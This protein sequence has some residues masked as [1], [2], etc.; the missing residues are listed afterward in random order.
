MVGDAADYRRIHEADDGS[1]AGVIGHVS[2]SHVGANAW[3]IECN[4]HL[5]DIP[6]RGAT[7]FAVALKVRGASGS[8]IRLIAMW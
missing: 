1:D 3:G 4:A 5:A 2:A 7:V 6:L 8:P